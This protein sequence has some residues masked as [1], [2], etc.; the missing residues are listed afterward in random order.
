MIDEA[1]NIMFAD[2]E[3][4]FYDFIAAERRPNSDYLIRTHHDR[5]VKLQPE[6]PSQSLHKLLQQL[7]ASGYFRLNLQRSQLIHISN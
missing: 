7:P 5:P 1:M 3:A 4:D 6:A 2:R